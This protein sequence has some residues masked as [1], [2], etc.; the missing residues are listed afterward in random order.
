MLFSACA[1][2]VGVSQLQLCIIVGYYY[3][4]D[5]VDCFGSV[6]ISVHLF[7]RWLYYKYA[8]FCF[9]SGLLYDRHKLR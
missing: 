2:A 7:F 5:I 8:Y 6:I 1:R 9:L 3:Y 4:C